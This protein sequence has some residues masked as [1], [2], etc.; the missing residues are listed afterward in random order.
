MEGIRILKEALK[1]AVTIQSIDLDS[2]LSL[3]SEQYDAIFL[4]GI[5]YHLKNPFFVLEK[6]ARIARRC[7]LATRVA[8]KVPDGHSL[9]RYPV[10]YLLAPEE[11]NNDS[12]NFWIVSGEGLKRLIHRTGWN[13][14]AYTT[15]GTPVTERRPIHSMTSEPFAFWKA[16]PNQYADIV[17]KRWPIKSRLS[18]ALLPERC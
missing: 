1:S 16:T 2:Q 3:P 7:S 4:L 17:K 6:L 12:T 5:L 14:L 9:A 18:D 13:I 11:C 10:A 15:I 8:K